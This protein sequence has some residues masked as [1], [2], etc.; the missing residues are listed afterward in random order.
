MRPRRYLTRCRPNSGTLPDGSTKTSGLAEGLRD[1]FLTYGENSF[2]KIDA[3]Q[4]PNGI[5]VSVT[6]KLDRNKALPCRVLLVDLKR[7]ENG[8]PCATAEL[9]KPDGAFK[10]GRVFLD[11]ASANRDLFFNVPESWRLVSNDGPQIRYSWGDQRERGSIALELGEWL[12]SVEIEIS[13]S[14]FKRDISYAWNGIG[15]PKLRLT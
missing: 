13:D 12:A 1:Q 6:Q 5:L 9:H 8:E 11:L 10:Y 2:Y 4:D 7:I 15:E 14:V 3:T